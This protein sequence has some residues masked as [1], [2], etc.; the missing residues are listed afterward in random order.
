[1]P[2]DSSTAGYLAPAP[3]PAPLEGQALNRFLQQWIV[4]ITGLAGNLV[5]PRWQAEPPVIPDAATAWCAIGVIE[6]AS[7]TYP[8]ILHDATGLG[9]DTIRRHELLTIMASFFDTGV[10]GQADSF[11]EIFREGAMIPQ[12]LE[13]LTQADMGIVETG[14]ATAVPS[15]LKERWLYQVDIR[16]VIR[17]E[18]VRSYPVL[19]LLSSQGTLVTDATPPTPTFNIGVP[20]P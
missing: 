13:A 2:N 7:D 3:S 4:G 15:L 8:Y 17:R 19:N 11:A 20:H 18:I 9:S 1:M 14:E 16:V 10:S 6:R 5:R 12:N